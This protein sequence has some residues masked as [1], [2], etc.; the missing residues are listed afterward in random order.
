MLVHNLLWIIRKTLSCNCFNHLGAI[1]LTQSKK[2]QKVQW[3][4]GVLVI[5]IAQIHST[6]LQLRFCADSNLLH[7]VSDIRYREDFWQ[8]SRL[9]I[10][11]NAFCRSIIPQKQFIIIII[12]IIIIDHI[13]LKCP[14]IRFEDFMILFKE[15]NRFKLVMAT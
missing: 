15:N 8:W 2:I 14:D 9:K 7:G 6:K 12:I 13:M 11:L 1:S 4:R 5:T 3:R 10:R